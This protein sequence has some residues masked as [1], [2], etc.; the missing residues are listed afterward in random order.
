MVISLAGASSTGK[1]TQ[2]ELLKMIPKIGD[3]KVVIHPEYPRILYE[4]LYKDKFP[5]FNDVLQR[6]K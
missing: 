3:K 6:G 1:T 5:S 4:K 2:I